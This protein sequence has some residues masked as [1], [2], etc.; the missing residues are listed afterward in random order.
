MIDLKK[1]VKLDRATAWRTY[2][3]GSQIDAI[4][5]IK[6]AE[7][8]NF[9]EEWMISTVRARNTGREDIVEGISMVS[10]T[11]VSL[12][13]L[14][15]EHA[16]TLLGKKHFEKYGANLGVL[17][18]IIDAAERLTIQ[19]HP[20]KPKARE[21]FS[22]DY[23][24]T[25]CWHILGGREIDGEKPC[26]YFGFKEGIT[27]EYWKEV[28]DTQNIPAMLSCLHKFEAKKGDT[29]FIEGGV[30]HCIGAGC[31]LVEIQEPTDYTI[32]TE[33][34]TPKGL[35]VADGMCHQGLGFDKMFDCFTY[36]GYSEEKTLEKWRVTKAG[37]SILGYDRTDM[38]SLEE[39]NIDGEELFASGGVF[40]GIYVLE[41]EGMLDNQP[42][43]PGSQYFVGASC[44]GF[45]IS[46]KLK[47][48]RFYGPKED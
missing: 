9:P 24:K 28:F 12:A 30:P 18:K 8:T 31:L 5:G 46:G 7:D 6:N 15:S 42:L 11:D 23:G 36:K 25:E 17:C 38:F 32:R 27:R 3:G 45:I 26:I 19:V 41:G 20:T 35:Q 40:S 29:F 4:H 43:R 48:L 39:W 44:D 22:S 16:E 47:I 1:P 34:V 14:V 37:N 2:I 13:D 33:R 10:G 21:L